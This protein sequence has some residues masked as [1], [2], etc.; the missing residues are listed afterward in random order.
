MPK[1]WKTY[2]LGDLVEVN[3]NSIR[4]GDL[5]WIHYID[6]K[7]VGS[8]YYES[9]TKLD[10]KD[11]PSRARRLLLE[12]DTVISSVRP[13]LKSFFYANN[14]D[15]NAIASTG[16]AVLTPKRIEPRFLYYLTTNDNY[17]EYLVQSCTGSAYP[18]FGPKVITDSTVT[19]PSI[20][21][22]KAIAG[23]LSAIDDKIE[24]NLAMNKTLEDMAMALYKHWFVDFG[25]FKDGKFID[26]ELGL[27]PEGWEVKPI[28]DVIDTVG[29]GTPKTKTKEYWEDGTINWYSPTDLTK[30]NSLYSNKSAKK[31]TSLGLQKSSARLF[32][33][34]SLL[35]SSRATIGALTINRKEAC[36]NQGFITMIPNENVCVY[37]LHGWAVDN[38]NLIISKANGSTFKEIS[39]TN[40]RALPILTG[41]KIKEYKLEVSNS[42]KRI[43]SNLLEIETLT[44]LRDT[45]LPKLISGEVRLK[46]F[47]EKLTA[48]L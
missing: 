44:Q 1:T 29:G 3:S 45:L 24:N 37:Q 15:E 36:T 6:I 28:G 8:G 32:P 10:F 5:D 14:L 13:N 48:A 43:E 26:S 17:I 16:F 23:I 34:G 25:P 9:P 46:E 41:A 18:A 7:S 19:I 2:K 35:M 12:G 47:E 27:I 38:M 31:I 11:A 4:K 30:S 20:S 42:Y 21:E 33:K 22:Q 39:K 40:F